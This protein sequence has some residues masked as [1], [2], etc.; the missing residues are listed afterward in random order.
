[1]AG[2]PLV[3]VIVAALFTAHVLTLLYLLRSRRRSGAGHGGDAAVCRCGNCG[4]RNDPGYRFCRN[5]V[6]ELPARTPDDGST[7]GRG[8][9]Y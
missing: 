8:Q 6:T 7:A 4:E 5:C 2:S 1:M 9:P 3:A